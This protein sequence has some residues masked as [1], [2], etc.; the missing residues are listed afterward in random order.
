MVGEEEAWAEIQ[1]QCEAWYEF[2]AGW[3]FYTEPTVKTFELGQFAKLSITK[4]RMKH[5]LK[6]LDRVLLAAMEFDIFEVRI[7]FIYFA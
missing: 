5:N 2:L 1:N 6:H 4:M 3:L 7:A